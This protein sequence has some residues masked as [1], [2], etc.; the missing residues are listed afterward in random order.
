MSQSK[1]PNAKPR[2]KPKAK[3]QNKIYLTG[4][5]SS[6]K[7]YACDNYVHFCLE[8]GRHVKDPLDYI[9]QDE[10]VLEPMAKKIKIGPVDPADVDS[11]LVCL[12]KKTE[13]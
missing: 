4:V 8:Y 11:T 10:R 1:L 12:I 6:G 13:K 2:A 5:I 3:I 7:T 9:H